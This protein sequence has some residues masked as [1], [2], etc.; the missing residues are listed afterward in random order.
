M[1]VHEDHASRLEPRPDLDLQIMFNQVR[2]I[3]RVLAE[4]PLSTPLPAPSKELG[5]EHSTK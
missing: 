5:Q 2:Q 1:I 4:Y 3:S